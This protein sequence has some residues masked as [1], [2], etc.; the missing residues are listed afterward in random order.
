MCGI[1]GLVQKEKNRNTKR[2]FRDLFLLSESRGKEA[3]GFA[4]KIADQIRIFKTPFPASAIVKGRVFK[5]EFIEKDTNHGSSFVG[6][7]HS[8]L[9]TNGYEQFDENNQPVVKNGIIAIH[10]GIIVNQS[11]LWSNY[12]DEK[13]ISELDSELIP[14]IISHELKN[15]NDLCNAIGKLFVE[16]SGMT[17]IALLSDNFNNLML[18]TN[19][20]SIYYMNDPQNGIFI[21]ASE[22]YIIKQVLRKHQFSDDDSVTQ[23]NPGELLNVNLNTISIQYARLGDRLSEVEENKQKSRIVYLK[24]NKATKNV[25]LNTSLDHKVKEVGEEFVDEYIKRKSLINDLRRC[26]RCI[27]PETFPFIEFDETGV[28]NYCNGYHKIDYQGKESLARV[29]D[30]FRNTKND[31]ECLMPFSGGRDSSYALH[32]AVK[33]LGLKPIAFSY[34][35]GMLTDLAR[36]NQSRMCGK[37]GIEHILVSADIRKKR[38]NIRKNVTAW[39]KRP[40]LGTIPLFMAGDKQYFYHSKLLKKQNG[41]DLVIMGE[42]HLEKTLFKSA[43]S[44]ARQ[45]LNGYMAYHISGINKARMLSYYLG[46]YL[47]NPAFLNSSLIDTVGAFLSYYAIRH[48][49]L[50]LYN[51][52]KW[53]EKTITDTLISDYDWETDPGS[54]TTWRIG[55]GTAAFYNYIYYMLTGFSENDTFRS[56]QIREGALTREKAIE[57]S[58]IENQPRWDSIQWYCST[59]QINFHDAL[60]VIN[61]AKRLF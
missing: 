9:V 35:W 43:F 14:T 53:D 23:L 15:G 30:S 10:N 3:S 19:N 31:P 51:F 21:F 46:Q 18:A 48:N 32:Y 12:K 33:E 56:N 50:N 57:L 37:L 1:F 22:K 6:M 2:I 16:I 8:R 60:I 58:I 7:G 61:N 44:G 38:E 24:E 4:I 49:Y 25:Y 36:R 29:V 28:C 47:K 34:D 42:N 59:I 26:T 39:L 41:I 20:G 17:N 27:L 54:M 11:E 40:D 5:N 45:D 55:D 13:R 52:I